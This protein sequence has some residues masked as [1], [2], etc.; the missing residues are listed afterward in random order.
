MTI[1]PFI[2]N[3]TSSPPFSEVIRM[4]GSS[5]LMNVTWS[6]YAQRWYMTLLDQSNTTVWNGAMVGSPLGTDIYLAPDV[7]NTSTILF[8]ED[9]GNIEVNP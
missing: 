7:F 1:I 4:D 3:N 9:T 5:Y 8:R 2:P 6:L